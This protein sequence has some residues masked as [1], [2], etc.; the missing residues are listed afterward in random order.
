[1]F[2]ECANNKFTSFHQPLVIFQGF[3][4]LY[5]DIINLYEKKICFLLFPIRFSFSSSCLHNRMILYTREEEEKEDEEQIVIKYFVVVV[6]F[7]SCS[8]ARSL[9]RSFS[10]YIYIFFCFPLKSRRGGR[11]ILIT[12]SYVDLIT[13]DRVHCTLY[14]SEISKNTHIH[15]HAYNSHCF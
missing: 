3:K 14:E 2:Q 4:H 15:L 12:T 7:L 5:V 13:L 1:M 11:R 10:L 6:I 8:R 9:A